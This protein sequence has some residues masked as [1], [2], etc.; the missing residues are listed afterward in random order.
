M[1]LGW[2]VIFVR[3]AYACSSVLVLACGCI[4]EDGPAF[5]LRHERF[6]SAMHRR[7]VAHAGFW[8]EWS[9]GCGSRS[10]AR[11]LVRLDGGFATPQIFEFLEAEGCDYVVAMA[12]S[13]R[14]S[15]R[16]TRLMEGAAPCQMDRP[17]R[18]CVRRDS[19]R[20][21]TLEKDR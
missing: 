9:N 16:S 8:A 4:M 1:N 17:H 7:A 6:P 5:K 10:R 20:S 12:K 13:V 2:A 18:P 21:T 14:L 11:V 15:R 19:V 3:N